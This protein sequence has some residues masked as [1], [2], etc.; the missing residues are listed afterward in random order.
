MFV[1]RRWICDVHDKIAAANKHSKNDKLCLS[2]AEGGEMSRRHRHRR[3]NM[4]ISYMRGVPEWKKRTYIF[5][6][7][8]EKYNTHTLTEKNFGT[9]FE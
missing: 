5:I 3:M 4:S 7:R 8:I 1:L 9:H 2:R 6:S